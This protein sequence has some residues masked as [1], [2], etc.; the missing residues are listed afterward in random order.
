ML[1][2][3]LAGVAIFYLIFH[4]H[5]YTHEYYHLPLLPVAAIIIGKAWWFF[6]EQES[7]PGRTLWNLPAFRMVAVLI[8]AGM[9]YGYSNGGFK[10]PASVKDFYVENAS[11]NRNTRDDDLII[12]SESRY[13]YYG[14]NIGWRLPYNLKKSSKEIDYWLPEG[15]GASVRVSL[16]EAWRKQGAVYFFETDPKTFFQ[17]R[18][19]ADHM[20]NNYPVADR[21]EGTYILFNLREK[22]SSRIQQSNTHPPSSEKL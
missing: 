10:L 14:D 9:V 19:L 12:V 16:I 17:H 1:G 5:I 3:W 21:E 18:E 13:L 4:K 2:F 15:R 6:F 8:V 20:M 11:L 22:I 7:A